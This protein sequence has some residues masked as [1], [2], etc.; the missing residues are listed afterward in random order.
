M[1]K[2]WLGVGLMACWLP[3][4]AAETYQID[5]RGLLNGRTVTTLSQGNLVTWNQG[6]D[7][8]GKADGLLTLEAALK[9][10]D[11]ALK[12]LPGDG[13]FPANA[14]HPEVRLNYANG[15]GT[16]NQTLGLGGEGSF[17]FWL[18]PRAYS[19]LYLFMTSAEGASS[20]SM[21]LTYADGFQEQRKVDQPDYYQPG[22]G[23]FFNLASDLAKWDAS[24]HMTEADHHYIHGVDLRPK[25]GHKLVKV[26]VDKAKA[27]YLVFWGATGVVD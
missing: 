2:G 11:K 15:D 19:H 4:P 7:G 23:D 18:P 6:V 26:Q 10:G 20:L 1:A 8:G 5:V 3:L 17:H 27:G 16:S 9:V 25:P 24:N 13:V 12:A 22:T 14:Q 21:T